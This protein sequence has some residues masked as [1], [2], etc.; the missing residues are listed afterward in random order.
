MGEE[1]VTG[2]Q[3]L[4][5]NELLAGG[6]AS[7]PVVV[8]RDNNLTTGA[9]LVYGLLLLY[10]YQR[11]NYPGQ[12]A[13]GAEFGMSERSVRAHLGE[14]VNR[15]YLAVERPGL[16]KSNTYRVLCPWERNPDRQNLPVK[17]AKPAGQSGKICRSQDVESLETSIPR[18]EQQQ[19]PAPA[20]P[21]VVEPASLPTSTTDSDGHD[22]TARLVALGVAPR[23]A[24]GWV[25]AKDREKLAD[26]LGY[27][28]DRAREGLVSNPAGY[29]ARAVRD[30]DWPLPDKTAKAR[31]VAQDRGTTLDVALTAALA[32]VPHGGA[33]RALQVVAG[34]WPDLV[35]DV[36]TELQRRGYE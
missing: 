8:A 13:M 29:L 7:V 22:L 9:K 14:L 10:H 23:T 15:G 11:R 18:K 6:F 3:I 4:V 31:G 32:E 24:A 28:E 30:G 25:K 5:E 2:G 26:L 16:G 36:R 34:W 19:K 20:A 35:G 21:V 27:T 17:A 12:V 33:D 1:Q